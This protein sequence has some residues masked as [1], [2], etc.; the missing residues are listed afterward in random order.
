M[1]K[2]KQSAREEILA[3]LKTAGIEVTLPR[4]DVPMRLEHIKGQIIK[5][6]LDL[7]KI[8]DARAEDPI[9]TK[10][11][12]NP[13]YKESMNQYVASIEQT[14]KSLTS[15]GKKMDKPQFRKAFPSKKGV[16]RKAI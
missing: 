12:N 16:F 9:R 8:K 2:K 6:T 3:D 7:K 4:P 11:Q 10:E 15:S 14:I 1:M 13:E 5:L